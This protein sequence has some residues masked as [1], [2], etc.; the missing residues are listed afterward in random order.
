MCVAPKTH[1]LYG[2]IIISKNAI[3]HVAVTTA[4]ECYGVASIGRRRR[5]K[6][7]LSQTKYG[8]SAC[9]VSCENNRI[10]V[11]VSLF[12]KFGV[13]IDPVIES[14]RRA[15]RYNVET[16]TGMTVECVNIN[17]LGIRN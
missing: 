6:S 10:D 12:L 1:N 11:T 7:G 15:V 5:T 13:T 9:K 16:F 17:V 4:A 14:V 8:S 2:K 3:K